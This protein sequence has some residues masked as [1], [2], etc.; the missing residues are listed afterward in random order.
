MIGI[1]SL[2]TPRFRVPV[3]PS[4]WYLMGLVGVMVLEGWAILR[5]DPPWYG[6]VCVLPWALWQALACDGW[7]QRHRAVQWIEVRG[8]EWLVGYSTHCVPARVRDDSVVWPWLV[9]VRLDTPHRR[10]T[11]TL[12]PD[13]TSREASRQL[14]VYLRWYTPRH[15]KRLH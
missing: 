5:L 7:V 11:V 12:W 2:Q 15:R 1:A 6:V 8:E 14:R 10:I 3:R 13:S 4:R 9:V